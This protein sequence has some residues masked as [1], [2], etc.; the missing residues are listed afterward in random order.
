[1]PLTKIKP[2]PTLTAVTYKFKV[3]ALAD[4]FEGLSGEQCHV[5]LEGA[6]NIIFA[7]PAPDQSGLAL[8]GDLPQNED[9]DLIDHEQRIVNDVV[10]ALYA[11]QL[12]AENS[13]LVTGEVIEDGY[14]N[15]P[16]YSN[17]ETMFR[18]ILNKLA[19]EINEDKFNQDI[20]TLYEEMQFYNRIELYNHHYST[21]SEILTVTVMCTL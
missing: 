20:T 13:F 15:T 19:D 5:A 17:F 21:E 8:E 4:Y 2:E 7:V 6:L 9:E 18:T 16:L 1:M 14:E 3:P 11:H 10:F 12:G